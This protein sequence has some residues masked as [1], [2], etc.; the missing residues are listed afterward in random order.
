[1]MNKGDPDGRAYLWPSYMP[2]VKAMATA[3]DATQEFLS[4]CE[5]CGMKDHVPKAWVPF[6]ASKRGW[7]S[8]LLAA[9]DKRVPAISPVVMDGLNMT[10]LFHRWYEN[11]GGWTFIAYDYVDAGVMGA[12]DTKGMQV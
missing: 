6:G 8:W 12:I 5:E 10:A 11:Y 7:C 1:M 2:M 9:V 4:Q 3:M